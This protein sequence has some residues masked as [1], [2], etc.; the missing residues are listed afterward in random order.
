MR[1]KKN[2][3]EEKNLFLL[4]VLIWGCVCYVRKIKCQKKKDCLFP[5]KTRYKHS[6]EKKRKEA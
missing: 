5:H 6:G 1:E 2:K 4:S 3:K